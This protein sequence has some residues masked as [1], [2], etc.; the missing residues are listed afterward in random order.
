MG[1][2]Q[3]P[4]F[5]YN[6]KRSKV[7]TNRATAVVK[8]SPCFFVWIVN[9]NFFMFLRRYYMNSNSRFL[10]EAP[11]G[12]LLLK[13]AVPCTLSLLVSSLYNIVDQIFI[14][15]GV[16]YLGNGATNV[17]FPITVIA[18][19]IA[20]MIGDGSAAY[21]SLCQGQGNKKASNR[22]VGNAVLLMVVVGIVLMAVLMLIRGP[23]LN[24]FGATENNIAYARD[25]FD[26]IVL[27]IPFF[28]FCN[29]MASIIRADGSP[30]FAMISVL[31]GCIMNIILDPIAIF[32][33][34][35]G[36]TG[37]A[38]A[39]IMGQ[40][41]SAVLCLV[42]L[43][44]ARTFRLSAKELVPSWSVIGKFLPLGIS[45]FLTQ[46]SIVVIMA[47]MN[48]TLV[49]YGARSKFGPDIPMTVQGIVMKLFQI[50]ISFVV[51]VAAGAQPIFGYN[52]GAGRFDRVKQLCS[53]MIKAE[54][55]IGLIATV[56]FEVFPLQLISIFG[57][58]DGLYNEY[59][60][61]CSRIYMSSILLCC[62]QKAFSIFLQAIGRPVMAMSL[63]LLRDFALSVIFTLL[64]P[65]FI[66]PGVI[67]PL[68]SAPVADT[69]SFIVGV[70]FLYKAFADM[71]EDQ[72]EEEAA[73]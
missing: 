60:V 7:V 21:L 71:N 55:V 36:V 18:L 31:V 49:Y 35:W 16:G 17:V 44:R 33:L 47:V 67:A 24:L 3:V 39:T 6:N 43:F 59:A 4:V 65:H 22:T 2:T 9:T 53:L 52:Y 73:V 29:A 20:L 30:A 66:Q 19:A 13:F 34:H 28:V 45:S 8:L 32:V 26:V 10:E 27:G 46:L 1:I 37:A 40:I 15:R 58:E 50:A 5:S 48:Q 61:L 68:F 62:L 64:L 25:Y 63:S 41:V 56:L 12:K 72:T 69:V 14:G 54:L 11:L 38:I 51:G 23:V 70:V 42:Y 57:A